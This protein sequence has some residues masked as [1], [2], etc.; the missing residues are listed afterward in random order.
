MGSIWREK[1]RFGW[2]QRWPPDRENR[3]IEKAL[4]IFMLKTLCAQILTWSWCTCP[5]SLP[6]YRSHKAQ[7]PPLRPYNP[8]PP[9]RLASAARS[10]T[11][12]SSPTLRSFGHTSGIPPHSP[13]PFLKLTRPLRT[14]G[15]T[16]S[17]LFLSTC[18]P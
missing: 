17:Q 16:V 18:V 7:R 14:P 9:P 8:F 4:R 1:S 13:H 6:T 5:A 11:P 2:Q 15:F 12:P 3:N 10:F